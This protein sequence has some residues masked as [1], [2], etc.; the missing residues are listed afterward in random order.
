MF[1]LIVNYHHISIMKCTSVWECIGY[2]TNFIYG[3]LMVPPNSHDYSPQIALRPSNSEV[4][5]K[6]SDLQLPQLSG[7]ARGAVESA[8]TPFDACRDSH[9][10]W[11]EWEPWGYRLVYLYLFCLTKSMRTE[12]KL[13]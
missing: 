7:G 8:G 10:P 5:N 6:L 3:L 2:V 1:L 4:Q 11:W 13:D 9:Q 12:K